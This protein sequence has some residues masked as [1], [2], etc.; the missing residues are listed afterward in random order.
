MI[1]PQCG[2]R[3]RRCA[4]YVANLTVVVTA[5]A[6]ALNTRSRT[7]LDSPIGTAL[8][9]RGNYNYTPPVVVTSRRTDPS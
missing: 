2:E 5:V 9:N 7:T 1:H 8:R 6:I 4:T 3:G